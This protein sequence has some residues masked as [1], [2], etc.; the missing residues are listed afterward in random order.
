[1]TSTQEN[2]VT[3]TKAGKRKI[4]QFAQ[5]GRNKIATQ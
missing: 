4:Q 1:M 3:I 5:F 2:S